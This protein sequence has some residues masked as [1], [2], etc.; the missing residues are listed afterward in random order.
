MASSKPTFEKA[1]KQLE[2]IVEE[3]ESGTLP[4]EKALKKFEEGMALSRYC[5]EKLEETE[6]RI[7]LLTEDEEGNPV[8]APFGSEK[9]GSEKGPDESL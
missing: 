4:L 1:M 6:R 2:L 3:L 8:E 9:F 7:S 5:N